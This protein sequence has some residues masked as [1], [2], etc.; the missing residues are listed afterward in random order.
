[1]GVTPE[2]LG[3]ELERIHAFPIAGPGWQDGRAVGTVLFVDGFGNIVT[4]I[5]RDLLPVE[6]GQHVR[7]DVGGKTFPCTSRS[8][9][10]DS[11]PGELILLVGSQETY[12]V[13]LNRQRA[14]ELVGGREGDRIHLIP[15][16][17]G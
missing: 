3:T 2:E 17:S 9:Y 16:E 11:E 14:Q 4:N 6:N 1:M 7:L 12:E 13:S 5:P 10:A 15:E 8:C